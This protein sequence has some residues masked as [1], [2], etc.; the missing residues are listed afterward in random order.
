MKKHT[1]YTQRV[2]ALFMVI[3]LSIMTGCGFQLRGSDSI[4]G[5]LEQLHII[6]KDSHGETG[7]MVKRTAE[8]YG[9]DL[10]PQSPW[11][12]DLESE[13]YRERRLTST[14]S[15]TQDEFMLSLELTFKLIHQ[16]ADNDTS[17]G[18]IKVKREAIFQGDE[19]QA[20]SKDNEKQLLLSELR[21]QIANQVLRQTFIVSNNPPD[22]DCEHE[23]ESTT[24]S[25]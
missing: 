9:I 3:M 25:Q 5:E 16:D 14:Q 1:A 21:Q 2:T 8:A 12:V 19:N 10:T 4:E 13:Q 15:V 23:T 11:T 24:V 6:G 7:K 22:C 18:P 17:Y 20:A